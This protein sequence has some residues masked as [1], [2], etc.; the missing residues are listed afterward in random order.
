MSV[1]KNSCH[2][3]LKISWWSL[4]CRNNSTKYLSLVSDNEKH[5]KFERQIYEVKAKEEKEIS[6]NGAGNRHFRR[7]QYEVYDLYLDSWIYAIL[8]VEWVVF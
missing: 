1:E 5:H 6:D 7:K 3:Q 4:W 2:I 8:V